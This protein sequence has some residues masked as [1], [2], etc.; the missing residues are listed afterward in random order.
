[1]LVMPIFRTDLARKYKTTLDELELKQVEHNRLVSEYETKL[2][3]KEVSKP[4]IMARNEY[5][6]KNLSMLCMML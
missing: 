6:F 3:S 5:I 2:K 1:M 4:S